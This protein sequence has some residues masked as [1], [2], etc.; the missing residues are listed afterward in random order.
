MNPKK[1][2]VVL[3]FGGQSGEHDVSLTSAA[4]VF[5]NLDPERY[6]IRSIYI[7]REGR[8]REVTSPI[9]KSDLETGPFFD[10]LPW[11]GFEHR[12][13]IKG[14]IYFP[15][16]HG[17]FG[18]DGT[19]QGLFELAGVPYVGAGVLGSAAGM[20]K[21]AAKDV[22]AAHNIPQVRHM[23]LRD[24][25]WNSGRDDILKSIKNRFH[26]PVFTKPA[27]LGSSVGITKVK[28]FEDFG[29]AAQT[30]FN[31]DRKI[32]IEQGVDGKEL[33]CSV[34]GDENP[35]ASLPG[36]VIPARDFYDYQDKYLDGKTSFKLPAEISAELT[37]RIQ[38][39][40]VKA[41]LALDCSGMARVDF[42]LEN[43]SGQL[44]VNEINTI[45]GFTEISMYPKL[46]EISGLPFTKLLDTLIDLGLKRHA[47]RKSIHP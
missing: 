34:L 27:N 44:Y 5:R 3:L 43:E 20:D 25:E 38:Q 26:P 9:E 40:A 30:A 28:N 15:V 39:L 42:F 24:S 22:F 14:D 45:P 17:P 23:T 4:A 12:P 10:F 35:R 36:E 7:S 21:A 16:L 8:W 47:R 1:I 6:N 19:I 2:D 37:E 31:F 41:F 13:L 29:T 32:I 33:E 18:E 46:W 11:S